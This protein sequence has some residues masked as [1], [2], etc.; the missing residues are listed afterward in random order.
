M[1]GKMKRREIGSVVKGRD[2]KPD[3]IKISGDVTLSKGQFVNLESPAQ[4]R[5]NLER[6]LSDGKL[7]AELGEKIKERID[8]IPDFVR[9]TLTVNEQQS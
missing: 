4:Q 9:F 5:A 1:A 3:Y 2:G 6:A 7:S 8:N